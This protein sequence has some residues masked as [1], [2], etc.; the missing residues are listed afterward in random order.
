MATKFPE[1]LSFEKLLCTV[2]LL[3][4]K[5]RLSTYLAFLRKESLTGFQQKSVLKST[6]IAQNRKRL[7]NLL[8]KLLIAYCILRKRNN[9]EIKD[10][11]KYKSHATEEEYLSYW[12]VWSK[13]Q[14][15]CKTQEEFNIRMNQ[16]REKILG[17]YK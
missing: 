8:L 1:Q 14:G 12:D 10:N 6:D 5:E 15:E 11:D 7:S 17:G 4:T 13:L 9:M 2:P 3:P 16:A